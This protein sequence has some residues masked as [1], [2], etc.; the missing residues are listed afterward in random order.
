MLSPKRYTDGFI[1]SLSK[2][3]KL[4][5]K[6]Y[7]KILFYYCFAI[8]LFI[9]ISG[10][11]TSQNTTALLFQ[12]LFIPITVYFVYSVLIQFIDKK[13]KPTKSSS[14]NRGG[15]FITIV[16]FLL[17]F[18]TSVVRIVKKPHQENKQVVPVILSPSPKPI[19]TPYL[20]V[21][22]D[23]QKDIINVRQSPT[24]ASKI[25]GSMDK[26]KKYQIVSKINEWYEILFENEK[27]G[28]VNEAF[29]NPL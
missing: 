1:V 27:H 28:F 10:I 5:M 22:S 18:V 3:I 4:I 16:L 20:M 29:V 23:Y 8:A 26:E 24:L 12:L 14:I 17:L 7:K 19:I 25:I 13:T 15:F 9:S 11:L 2:N 21:R 6:N